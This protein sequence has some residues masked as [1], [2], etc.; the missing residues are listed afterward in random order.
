VASNKHRQ[1]KGIP[2]WRA[3]KRLLRDGLFNPSSLT[4]YT[5][6]RYPDGRFSCAGDIASSNAGACGSDIYA[7]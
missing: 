1:R 4:I 5:T 2:T 7:F 3:G 6:N